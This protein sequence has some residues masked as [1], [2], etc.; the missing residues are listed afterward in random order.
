[1]S[2]FIQ[3]DPEIIERDQHESTEQQPRA[4]SQPPRVRQVVSKVGEATVKAFE[5]LGALAMGVPDPALV[6]RWAGADDKVDLDKVTTVT[7]HTEEKVRGR[8]T[9]VEQETQTDEK[10]EGRFDNH[11]LELVNGVVSERERRENE[12]ANHRNLNRLLTLLGALVIGL[13]VTWALNADILGSV[14][15]GMAPYSFVITILMDSAL[16]AYGFIKKY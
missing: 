4:A 1:M 11:V 13:V 10:L 12:R 3:N 8:N 7:R 14:G 2:S 15:K 9:Y 16:A 5:P 6:D